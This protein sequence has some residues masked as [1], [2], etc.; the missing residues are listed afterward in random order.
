MIV[1]GAGIAGLVAAFQLKKKGVDVIVLESASKVGGRMITESSNGYLIDGGAQFLSSA[2]KILSD[3]I[4]ELGITPEYVET[5][6]IVGIVRNAK[7]RKFRYDSPL[8]L[9][10]SG[11]LTFSDWLSFCFG[12]FKLLK[13][14]KGIPINNYAAWKEFDNEAAES[15]SDRYYGKNITEYFVEPLLEA[16]YFQKPGETSKALPIALNAFVAHKAKTMTL[17]GGIGKLPEL[18]A[19]GLDVRLNTSVDKISVKGDGVSI[20]TANQ[21][22]RAEKVILATPAPQSR[23]IYTSQSAIEK[24][25][26]ST[27]FSS[28]VNIAFALVN[29]LPQELNLN[30]VYGVWI[31]RRERKII[32]AFTIES[33]KDAGRVA[34]G[35]LIHVMLSGEAGEIMVA[36]ND[37]S[38]ITDVLEE[39]EQYLPCISENVAFTR[40]Y[41]WINAEPKSR[42]GRCEKINDYR[43]S[44]NNHN[45]VILAG[46]YLGMPFT[47]G[48]AETGIWAASSVLSKA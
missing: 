4:D 34:S 25:L 39:L 44:I 11:L 15:W 36:Q 9:L 6:R 45:K 14:T 21:E 46:D 5:S 42:V 27:E 24:E 31:P 10:F 41:R 29:K 19:K 47:E 17:A 40:V 28:T 7:I 33:A 16:L 13:K 2:Y 43:K 37:E 20:Y 1:V 3:L 12:S 18:I 26:L 22:F 30:D 48:A 23:K 38:I 8:S 32:A 35:E